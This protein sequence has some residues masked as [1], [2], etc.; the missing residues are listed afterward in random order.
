MAEHVTS[1]ELV[2]FVK[3]TPN[4][5]ASVTIHHLELL[6]SDVISQ[7]GHENTT[8]DDLCNHITNPHYYCKPMP[9]TFSDRQAILDVSLCQNMLCAT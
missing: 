6:A 1:K 5:A 8:A 9:K 3:N 2:D 4:I 7:M